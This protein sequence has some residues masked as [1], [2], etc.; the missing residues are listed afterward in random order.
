MFAGIAGR[1]DFANR[2]LS[3][4]MDILWRRA[5]VRAV[6][7]RQPQA[8][9]DLATG[10][11]DV[12][13]E[14]ASVLGPICSLRGMDFC[15]PMLE[16]ARVKQTQRQ[17]RGKKAPEVIFSM[18]DILDLP[19]EDASVDVLTVAFGV[20]NLE[21]RHRGMVE[22]LRALRPGGAVICLE[23]SQPAAWFR[24]F[25]YAYLKFILPPL[26][27]LVTGDRDAYQ[28]LAGSIEAFPRREQLSAE[29]TQAGFTRVRARPLTFG[30]VALHEAEK[31][32]N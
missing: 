4:G 2:M 29:Y 19:L 26:A 17:Q 28:Y 23:F 6:K 3:G 24:P 31:A 27:G 18:G 16:E 21:D 25:Y 15:E 1:Y 30:V 14:L 13:L 9:V 5:M 20:R 7:A 10:S 22:M 12:A 11:G 8:V 32:M